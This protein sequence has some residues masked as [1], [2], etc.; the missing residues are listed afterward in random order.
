[1]QNY[2]YYAYILSTMPR[3]KKEIPLSDIKGL[4]TL[5]DEGKSQK[6]IAKYYGVDQATISRRIKELDGD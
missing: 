4:K 2:K 6:E 3:P 5:I 1:M